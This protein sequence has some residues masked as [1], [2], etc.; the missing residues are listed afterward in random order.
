MS[1]NARKAG[2]VCA[3]K[4]CCNKS[5]TCDKKFFPEGND[6]KNLTKIYFSSLI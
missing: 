5:Y 6:V 3:A 2:S 4:N 1:E